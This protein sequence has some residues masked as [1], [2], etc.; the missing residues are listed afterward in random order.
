[1]EKKRCC[2]FGSIVT[3]F[4]KHIWIR[5]TLQTRRTGSSDEPPSSRFENCCTLIFAGT[6]RFSPTICI[7]L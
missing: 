5:Q 3:K 2:I 4:V 6:I 7:K 1:M